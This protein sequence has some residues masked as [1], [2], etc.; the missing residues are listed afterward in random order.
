MALRQACVLSGSNQDNFEKAPQPFEKT[1]AHPVGVEKQIA[2][3]SGVIVPSSS[4]QRSGSVILPLSERLHVLG[5]FPT[6][7]I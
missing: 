7:I 5:C 2:L 6:G 1:S 4:I 3:L